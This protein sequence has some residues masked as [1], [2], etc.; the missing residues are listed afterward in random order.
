MK[1]REAIRIL[2]ALGFQEG[3]ITTHG[4]FWTLGARI[5]ILVPR[6][7]GDTRAHLNWKATLKKQ[8]RSAALL[9]EESSPATQGEMG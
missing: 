3:R 6:S 4:T 8:L 5:K 9:D 7:F 2:R 1:P